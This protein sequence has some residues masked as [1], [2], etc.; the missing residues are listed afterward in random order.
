MDDN[1]KYA[2]DYYKYL[3][4]PDCKDVTSYCKPHRIE[5]DKI[6]N[7]DLKKK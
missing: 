1:E 4:C 7:L 3:K 2:I 6:L 5:V